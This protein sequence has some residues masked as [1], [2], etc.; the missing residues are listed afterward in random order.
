MMGEIT[1]RFRDWFLKS[2]DR[3]EPED[4]DEPVELVVVRGPS[5]P[6]TVARLQAD[7]FNAA[8]YETASWKG[9]GGYRILV[10]RHQL[11]GASELLNSIL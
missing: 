6:M 10:P 1:V 3:D 4:P 5:G 9:V 11:Q 8:G 2:I 7:G